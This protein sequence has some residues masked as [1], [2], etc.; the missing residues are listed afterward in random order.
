MQVQVD[1]ERRMWRGGRGYVVVGAQT[2][3]NLAVDV[4]AFQSP[5]QIVVGRSEN[6]CEHVCGGNDLDTPPPHT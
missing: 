1:V 6:S 3:D 2:E 5:V 4:A